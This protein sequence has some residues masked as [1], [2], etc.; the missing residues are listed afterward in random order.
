[1]TETSSRAASV[2]QPESD[3]PDRRALKLMSAGFGLGSVGFMLGA[4]MS[5]VTVPVLSSVVAAAAGVFVVGAILFTC[6]AA[7]Q[8]RTSVTHHPE[9]HSARLHAESDLRNPDWLAAV[10]QLVGTLY[11]NVMTLWA[12]AVTPTTVANYNQ[13][14]WKPDVLGSLLFLISS[15]IACHPISRARR[16]RLLDNGR[17]LSIVVANLAGSILFGISAVGSYAIPPGQERHPM[18][19]NLGTLLGGMAFLVSAMLMWPPA[20]RSP[21]PTEPSPSPN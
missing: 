9:F 7:V 4:V 15:L 1:M 16:H 8:W 21:A 2:V 14:V 11:F 3:G 10:I 19:N 20:R 13:H 5:M 17:S 6:A 18:W 12:L